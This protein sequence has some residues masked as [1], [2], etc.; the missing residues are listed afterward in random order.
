VTWVTAILSEAVP[1]TV[2]GVALVLYVGLLV[3][4]LIVTIGAVGSYVTVIVSVEMFWATSRAVT[5]ITLSPDCS[6]IP[7]MVQLV[8]P[9]A[10]PLPPRL[11]DQVTLVTE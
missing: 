11:L 4:L 10:V 1:P 7:L 3:G 9:V 8:V 5:V 2:I 6:V